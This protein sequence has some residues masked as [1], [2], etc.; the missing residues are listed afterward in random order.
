MRHAHLHRISEPQQKTFSG[1]YL[2][3]LLLALAGVVFYIVWNLSHPRPVH[4]PS[5][6]PAATAGI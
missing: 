6:L 5:R 4:A 1:W 3:F 2:V